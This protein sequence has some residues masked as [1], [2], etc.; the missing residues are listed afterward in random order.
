MLLNAWERTSG[1]LY[2]YT[3]MELRRSPFIYDWCLSSCSYMSISR[4]T[5][6]TCPSTSLLSHYCEYL[7]SKWLL[8]RNTS[9]LANSSSAKQTLRVRIVFPGNTKDR[10][11]PVLASG[12]ILLTITAGKYALHRPLKGMS[13]CSSISLS[14]S[15]RNVDCGLWHTRLQTSTSVHL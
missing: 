10:M 7:Y 3:K 4:N 12:T 9:L 11:N 14:A 1:W 15:S 5:S 2:Y 8:W 6:K 13:E